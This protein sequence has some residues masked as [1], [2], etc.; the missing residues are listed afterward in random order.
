MPIKHAEVVGLNKWLV[1]LV[2]QVIIKLV[3]HAIER[4]A[5]LVKQLVDQIG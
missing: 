4:L 1:R 2:E 5:K 3:E